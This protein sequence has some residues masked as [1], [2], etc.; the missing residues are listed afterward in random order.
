M[1]HQGPY[2]HKVTHHSTDYLFSMEAQYRNVFSNTLNL[3]RQFFT[4]G[5]P[6]H[7]QNKESETWFLET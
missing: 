4:G 3:C 7:C 6:T 2:L 5:Y 1:I